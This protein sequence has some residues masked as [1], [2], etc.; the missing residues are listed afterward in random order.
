MF[1]RLFAEG[2]RE[3]ARACGRERRK[4]RAVFDSSCAIMG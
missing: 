3:K 1:E 2:K 4:V